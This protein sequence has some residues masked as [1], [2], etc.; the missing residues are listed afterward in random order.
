M[1]YLDNTV[2]KKKKIV[3]D[4]TEIG[5]IKDL[6]KDA[7]LTQEKVAKHCGV[8]VVAYQRWEHGIG[9]YI[10]EEKF[11]KLKEILGV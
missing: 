9:K 3:R 7:K 1:I 2:K 4:L 6:R 10:E 11:N 5:N 8:S